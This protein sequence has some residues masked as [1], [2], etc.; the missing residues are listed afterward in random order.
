MTIVLFGIYCRED[1]E[2]IFLRVNGKKKSDLWPLVKKY[3]HPDTNVICTD[4]A[5]QYTGVENLFNSAVHKSTNH[6]KGE[7]VD[8]ND[9]T[10]TINSLENQNKLLKKAVKNRRSEKG[11][12]QHMAVHFYRR[13]RLNHLPTLGERV[14]LFSILYSDI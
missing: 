14:F 12:Q 8:K 2:G 6:K 1:K 9:K 4:S 11:I 3:C 5:G 10:N 7:F 13:M